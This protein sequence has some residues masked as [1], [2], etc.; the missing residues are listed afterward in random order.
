M[1]KRVYCPF[2]NKQKA[3][4][5]DVIGWS[6]NARPTYCSACHKHS[7]D[8]YGSSLG[9]EGEAVGYSSYYEITADQFEQYKRED[10]KVTSIE[11]EAG[12]FLKS[13]S[14]AYD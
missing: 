13:R 5:Y 8:I 3:S 1:K 12:R 6:R 2:C 9:I 14:Y 7:V 4:G 10:T 11:K